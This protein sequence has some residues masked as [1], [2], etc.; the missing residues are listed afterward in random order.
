[1]TFLEQTVSIKSAMTE[2]NK[3]ELEKMAD[4]IAAVILS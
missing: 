3:K 2:E 1:M 4:E